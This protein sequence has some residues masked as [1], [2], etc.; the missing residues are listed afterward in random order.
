MQCA[1]IL[2]VPD[3][4]LS[5]AVE[6][7]VP[8]GVEGDRV[9][10]RQCGTQLLQRLCLARGCHRTLFYRRAVVTARCFIQK[11]KWQVQGVPGPSMRAS[12]WR[13]PWRRVGR[14]RVE[15]QPLHQCSAIAKP[16]NVLEQ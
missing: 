8:R 1:N 3:F 16:T 7:P 12:S 6:A 11:D 2:A 15:P 4:D 10:G 9:L 13:P 14:G 5:F